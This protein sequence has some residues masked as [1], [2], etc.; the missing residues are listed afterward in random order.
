MSSA[1][2]EPAIPVSE[3]PRTYLILGRESTGIGTYNFLPTLMSVTRQDRVVSRQTLTADAWVQTQVSPR[4]IYGTQN[5]TGAS[6]RVRD[7]NN[8]VL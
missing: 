6:V 4:G 2:F 3:R 7:C 8:S 1:G 5:G